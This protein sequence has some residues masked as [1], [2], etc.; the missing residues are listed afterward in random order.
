MCH[1]GRAEVDLAIGGETL[2]AINVTAVQTGE[3]ELPCH[4]PA[5]SP[6]A[7]QPS[8][9]GWQPGSVPDACSVQ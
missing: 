1:L 7:G 2:T 9:L 8:I 6:S 5:N 4:L 3:E